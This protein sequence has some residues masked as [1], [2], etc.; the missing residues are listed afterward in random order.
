MEDRPKSVI[1]ASAIALIGALF[2]LVVI[3]LELDVGAKGIG[4]KMT[5][6]VLLLVLF[7]AIAGSLFKNGQ[8]SWRFLIFMEV[9]CAVFALFACIFE[10]ID[11]TQGA[12]FIILACLMILFTTPEHAK[13]W[14]EADR[15]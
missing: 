7:I 4:L 10:I 6:C 15:V 13:R 14:V 1:A 8:W 2:A 3:T 9:F 12:I 5:V 11:L